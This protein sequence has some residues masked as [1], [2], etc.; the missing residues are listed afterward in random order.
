MVTCF[1][2]QGAAVCANENSTQK[3]FLCGMG[4]MGATLEDGAGALRQHPPVV[5]CLQ[6]IFKRRKISRLQK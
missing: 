6:L 1:S 4:N 3:I 2:P 5:N